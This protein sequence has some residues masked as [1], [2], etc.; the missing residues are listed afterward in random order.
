MWLQRVYIMK[1]RTTTRK[2]DH[3]PSLSSLLIIELEIKKKNLPI[4]LGSVYGRVY[5]GYLHNIFIV[6]S[7]ENCA[8]F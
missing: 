5:I 1:D 7:V 4:Y 2:W 6:G 3:I 8:L